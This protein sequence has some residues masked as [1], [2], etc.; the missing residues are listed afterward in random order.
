VSTDAGSTGLNLQSASI[1]VNLDIPWNPALLEQRAGRIYRIG[2]HRNVQIINF[3]AERTIEERMLSTLDFKANVAHGV[4]DSG[5]DNVFLDDKRFNL[6][7][8]SLGCII[9]PE[10]PLKTAV[11]SEEAE[12]MKSVQPVQT[13]ID[14]GLEDME[15]VDAAASVHVDVPKFERKV[16]LEKSAQDMLQQGVSFVSKLSDTLTS[17]DKTAALLDTIVRVDPETGKTKLEIPVPDKKT[18]EQML[19]LFSRLFLK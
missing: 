9:T 19:R 14:F 7:M 13:S 12:Q 3:V 17:P 15:E 6:L 2:Q 11:I 18:V 4:L 8:E 10:K 16:A 5:A 1:L